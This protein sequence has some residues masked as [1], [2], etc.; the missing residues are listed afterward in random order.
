MWSSLD[1]CLCR[2]ILE[3]ASDFINRSPLL[4]RLHTVASSMNTIEFQLREFNTG[5]FPR[6][7]SFML[8]AMSKW[9]YDNSPTGALKFEEPLAQLKAQ[10]AESGSKVFQDMIKELL[11]ENTHR[12]AV[13]MVPSKTLEAEQLKEEQDRLAA[14]KESL[15]DDELNEIIKKTSELKELQAAED[16]PEARAT[17]PSLELADLKREVTEYPFDITENEKDTGIK[18]VRHELVSTSGIAYVNFGVDVSSL[19]LEDAA[20]MPLFTRMMME[21]GAGDMDS[22]AL[23]RRIGTYTGG[24]SA[25]FMSSGVKPEDAEEGVVSDG[26]HMVTQIMIQGKATSDKAGELLSLFKLIL[27]DAKLD[28]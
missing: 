1:L 7:L 28:S 23:S 27:T 8:G 6:G 21:T 16:P 5:S 26:D 17:I 24:V 19:P 25:A 10:I 14:I 11:L 22:V 3:S 2:L 12:V 18:V 20:I 15:D 9:L 13:E 4:F